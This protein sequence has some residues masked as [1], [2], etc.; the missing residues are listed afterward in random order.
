MP[1]WNKVLDEITTIHNQ[2]PKALDTVRRKYLKRLYLHTKRNT[3]AYY[4]GWLSKPGGFESGLS[5]YDKN[6]FMT[7]IHELDRS[8][9][10]DLILHTP[11][12]LVSATES[13]V[14]YLHRMF[15]DNI[16][17]IIPQLAMS[18]GT[19][20]ACACKEI[21]MGEQSNLGPID[22]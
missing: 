19:M 1:N 14:D 17:A 2:S 3:L 11:G 22:P 21:I 18:G 5:D 9:G 6:G 13:I 10:L 12:G 15:G 7:T 16:R 8:K 4:S 20:I